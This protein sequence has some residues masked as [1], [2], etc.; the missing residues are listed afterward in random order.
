MEGVNASAHITHSAE[1]QAEAKSG[2]LL[3][4][5]HYAQS[6]GNPSPERNLVFTVWKQA[7]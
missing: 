7:F 1:L 6:E 2:L 4:L 3:I 5:G